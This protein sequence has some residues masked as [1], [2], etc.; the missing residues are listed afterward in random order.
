MERQQID[1]TFDTNH[2]EIT[3]KVDS[4][5]ILNGTKL[6]TRRVRSNNRIVLIVD[7]G[8]LVI[9]ASLS[10]LWE[11]TAIR[12]FA[13]ARQEFTSVGGKIYCCV[14]NKGKLT[15]ENKQN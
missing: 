14:Q 11:N 10:A 3:V 1:G 4:I 2:G 9:I 5:W 8:S 13:C 7:S 6:I 15:T 12:K